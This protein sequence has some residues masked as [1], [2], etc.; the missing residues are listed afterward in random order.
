AIASI[1]LL[2]PTKMADGVELGARFNRR[3]FREGSS[4]T[5]LSAPDT[6]LGDLRVLDL[7]TGWGMYAA[8]LLGELGA[9]VIKVEPALGCDQRYRGPY[10]D[11]KP[12]IEGSVFYWYLNTSK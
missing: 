8:K 10:L 1:P 3:S 4:M 7:S 2:P 12:D 6:A 9:D 5:Q 11:D